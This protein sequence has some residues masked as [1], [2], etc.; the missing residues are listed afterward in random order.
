MIDKPVAES[1]LRNQQPILE[2]LKPELKHSRAVLE[3]GSGTGQHAVFFAQAMPHLSWQASDLSENHPAITA[4]IEDAN[5][6]NVPSPIQLDVMDV[7]WPELNVDTIFSANSL[8]IMSWLAV[9]LFFQGVGRILPDQG[10][11]FVYGPMKHNGCY[12]SES[13]ERFDFWLK[14]RDPLSGIRDLQDLNK[15]AEANHLKPHQQWQM[16]ANNELICWKKGQI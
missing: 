4:W 10:R 5:L 15:L 1:C 13:N 9:Q 3:I 6:D 8:H 2:V 11:L 14:D 7:K 12:T 16:P